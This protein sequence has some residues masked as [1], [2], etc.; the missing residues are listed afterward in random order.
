MLKSDAKLR[1]NFLITKYF[2]KISRNIPALPP[3]GNRN[4]QINPQKNHN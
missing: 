4:R 1:T 3:N 2:A